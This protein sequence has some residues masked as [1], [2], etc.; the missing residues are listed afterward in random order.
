VQFAV[1]GG[2][3]F[4]PSPAEYGDGEKPGF[5]VPAVSVLSPRLLTDDTRTKLSGFFWAL[6][7][8]GA[9]GRIAV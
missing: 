8:R 3:C 7:A 5:H 6:G 4:V 2:P 1:A 9:A